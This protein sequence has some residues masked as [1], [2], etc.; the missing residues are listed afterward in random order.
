MGFI[1]Y[2]RG[3]LLMGFALL[4]LLSA[5]GVPLTF[6][7]SLKVRTIYVLAVASPLWLLYMLL[8]YFLIYRVL[9]NFTSALGN[10]ENYSS[11]LW[12]QRYTTYTKEFHDLGCNLQ[13]LSFETNDLKMG[14]QALSSF[15]EDTQEVSY[16]SGSLPPGV[17]S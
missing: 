17:A 1:V 2:F 9:V 3:W 8:F 6:F 10:D 16:L 14:T 15:Y 5:I 7:T 13:A 4:I 12:T 11:D